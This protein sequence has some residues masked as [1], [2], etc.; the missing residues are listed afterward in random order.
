MPPQRRASD[1]DLIVQEIQDFLDE[2]N[3]TAGERLKWRVTKSNYINGLATRL[4]VEDKECHTPKGL[5]VRAEVIGWAIFIMIII[6]TVV[7]Y[8]P[9]Q[10]GLLI[11]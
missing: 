5:L 10:I 1:S 9:E 7:T 6:S 8:L 2:N 4:H 3:L 11:K